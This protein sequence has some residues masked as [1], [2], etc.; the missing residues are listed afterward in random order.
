MLDLYEFIKLLE[1]ALFPYLHDIGKVEFQL[2][3]S[4]HF[5]LHFMKICTWDSLLLQKCLTIEFHLA[6]L[7][8]CRAFGGLE[9][10]DKRKPF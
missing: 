10:V 6:I 8:W 7:K 3:F 5:T 1:I 2:L 4:I 9:I